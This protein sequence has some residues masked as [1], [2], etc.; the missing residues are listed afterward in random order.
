[1]RPWGEPSHD[2]GT[3]PAWRIPH[4]VRVV[5]DLEI[6]SEFISGSISAPE[7]ACQQ[8]FGWLELASELEAAR[9]AARDDPGEELQT[10]P[11]QA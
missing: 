11:I 2:R 9:V 10:P 3:L 5:L 6:D 4:Q 1:M 7:Y 8:F